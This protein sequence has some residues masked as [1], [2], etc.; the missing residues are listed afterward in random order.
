M[1]VIKTLTDRIQGKAPKGAKRASGWSSFRKRFMAGRD[2]AVCSRK[3]GL[4]AH[5]IIPFHLAPDLELSD[6]NLICLCRRCHLFLGHVGAWARFNP[7][8]E[9]DAATWRM[10]MAR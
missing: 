3:K 6:Q 9:V 1:N 2:C 4:E 8:V 5:H 7:M 10:K